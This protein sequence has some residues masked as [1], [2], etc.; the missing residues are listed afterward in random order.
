MDSLGMEAL[1]SSCHRAVD[2]DSIRCFPLVFVWI[3][4]GLVV[5]RRQAG[6]VV[7]AGA[8]S[9]AS[10]QGLAA[11]GLQR[12]SAEGPKCSTPALGTQQLAAALLSARQP[13]V[14]C[15]GSSASSCSAH[16]CRVQGK[17][18]AAQAQ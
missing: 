2:F 9:N 8:S 3:S 5:V 10:R 14:Q 15:K 12:Q 7:L 16:E 4:L 17:P 13:A 11:Q 1:P 6:A 18:T